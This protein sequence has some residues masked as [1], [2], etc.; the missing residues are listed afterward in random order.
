MHNGGGGLIGTTR[1]TRPFER[2]QDAMSSVHGVQTMVMMMVVVID[3]SLD[4]SM[5]AMP[6]Q[7]L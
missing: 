1:E 7:T 3:T 2:K 6:V 4:L 5:Q